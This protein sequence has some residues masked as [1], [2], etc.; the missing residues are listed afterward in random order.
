MKFMIIKLKI[1]ILNRKIKKLFGIIDFKDIKW[2]IRKN[3]K[4]SERHKV[5]DI[6]FVKKIKKF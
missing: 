1:K 3:K 2:S 6:I 4:I 5:G